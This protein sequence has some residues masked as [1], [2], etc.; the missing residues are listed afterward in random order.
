MKANNHEQKL[1]Q[2]TYQLDRQIED[3]TVGD[4]YVLD[5]QLVRYDC[6]ASTAHAQMLGKIGILSEENVEVLVN[7]LKHIIELNKRANLTILRL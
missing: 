6:L 7:E 3:F 1:W 4:G 2:K 5:R